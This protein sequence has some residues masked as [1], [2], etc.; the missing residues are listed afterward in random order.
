MNRP[1]IAIFLVCAALACLCSCDRAA[2]QRAREQTGGDPDHGVVLIR[3]YGCASC[4]TIPG[5]R[6]ADSLVGPPLA[7]VASRMYVGGV[8][9]NT[10]ENMVRWVRNPKAI[11]EK[12][13]MPNLWVTEAD[14]RD[15]TSYLYTLR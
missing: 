9:R 7:H 6:G 14:A 1:S 11:D 10:P 2:K 12:T 15:I 5:I 8:I 13:A 4:H 3:Y